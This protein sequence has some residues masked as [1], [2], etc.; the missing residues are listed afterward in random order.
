MDILNFSN[1][2]RAFRRAHGYTQ[3]EMSE[4]LHI[5]RQTYCNYE[6]GRRMPSWDMMAEIASVLEI[7]LDSL[8][9]GSLSNHIMSEDSVRTFLDYQKLPAQTQESI[10]Q[11]I[12]SQLEQHSDE[13]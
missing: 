4:L 3:V 2:L 6:N 12:K 8:I 11:Y 7:S 9:R 13:S 5:Q 10:R 1:N